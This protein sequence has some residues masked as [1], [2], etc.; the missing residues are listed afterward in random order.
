MAD[1]QRKDALK[2]LRIISS[3]LADGNLNYRKAAGLLGRT[4]PQSHARAVAQMCDLLDAAACLGGVPP[5][6]LVRVR[7][8]SG[9][10]NPK[11]WNGQYSPY[12][13]GVIK[14]SLGYKFGPSDFEKI[15]RA[16]KDL[17]TRGNRA[18]WRYVHYLYPGD[19]LYRRVMGNYDG[20]KSNAVDD[21][22]TDAP[23][24]AKLEVW[25][26]NRDQKVRNAVLLR[27]NGRCEFCGKLGFLKPHGLRYLETHHVIAL[28]SDG[29]DRLTNVIA[30]CP[31]DHREAHFGEG[32]KEIERKMIL[33]LKR[34]NG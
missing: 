7:A 13:D 24:L 5:L 6:A 21:L 25:A 34:L 32:A 22:G 9:E 11:A 20:T 4:P 16:L 23:D 28:A 12:R 17:G 27:A 18:S 3:A 2:L 29:A 1:I 33:K 31:N 8:N 30:L 10:I 26:Y 19:L 15:R 14:R